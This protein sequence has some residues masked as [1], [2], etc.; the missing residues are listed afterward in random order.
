MVVAVG[1]ESVCGYNGWGGLARH[2]FPSV[3]RTG[4]VVYGVVLLVM[5]VG[6]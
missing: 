1:P 4:N 5:G 6:V 2:H 3:L